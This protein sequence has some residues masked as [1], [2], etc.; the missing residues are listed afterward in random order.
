MTHCRG[1]GSD[2]HSGVHPAVF[3]AMRAA[4][5]GH[6]HAYGDD[7]WTEQA[8]EVVR[9]RVGADCDVAFVFNGTGANCV[10]FAALCRD[11]ESVICAESAHVNQDECGAPEHLAGIKLV[12]VATPDGKLTPELVRPHLRGFGFEHHAQPRLISV[13]NV[14]EMGTVY[15]PEELSALADVAHEH[16]MLLHVDGA[17]I[18]NAAVALDCSLAEL[19]SEAGVDALSLGGTK[20]GMAFGEAV[21]LF[22]DARAEHLPYVRKHN[23]QLASKMRF[24]SAQFIALFDGDLWYQCA[25]S[26]NE[27]A[28]LLAE[29][30]RSRGVELAFPPEANEVFAY[31]PAERV[32]ELEA[33][34]HFYTWDEAVDPQGRL[35]VRWVTSWDTE[36]SD[37]QALLEAL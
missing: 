3:E 36:R 17:R 30:A 37:V 32:P 28:A 7:A 1:F 2:N 15:T 16:A 14:S 26:A 25:R 10:S 18:S 35:L 27:M 29:G 34:F 12:P 4:S 33:R 23:A 13:S 11:W 5:V 6:A 24:L 20:N 21:V 19:S 22:G 31:L 9:R 8:R